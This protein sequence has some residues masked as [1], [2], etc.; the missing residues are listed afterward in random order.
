M[1]KFQIGDKVQ[2]PGTPFVVEV[3]EIGDC[4]DCG[5]GEL[6]RLKDPESGEDDWMHTEEFELVP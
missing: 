1:S 5:P 3:L 2:M 6:F 4:D